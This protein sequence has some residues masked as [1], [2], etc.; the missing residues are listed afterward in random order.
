MGGRSGARCK[1][2]IHRHR[3]FVLHVYRALAPLDTEHCIRYS[4][5]G[6]DQ[7]DIQLRL[8]D[9]TMCVQFIEPVF[10]HGLQC[11]GREYYIIVHS[12]GRQ[13]QCA[14]Q[15]VAKRFRACATQTALLDN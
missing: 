14:T 13:V 10:S 7:S 1:F 6:L 12:G 15:C 4:R 9:V 8:R 11:N 3:A 2:W 5:H